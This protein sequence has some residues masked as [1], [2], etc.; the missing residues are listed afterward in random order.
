MD[1]KNIDYGSDA[2]TR[3]CE[4][5][6]RV[7]RV[8]LGLSLADEDLSE[9]SRQSHFG[10]FDPAGNLVACVI[11]VRLSPTR[12]KI[13]Q[14]AVCGSYQNQG[15]GRHIIR[16]L[17]ARL[18]EL[19]H[20]EVFMHARSGAVGFYE[21]LGYRKAGPEFVEV[22]IPHFLMEKRLSAREAGVV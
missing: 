9:E 21:K 2:F 15:W 1:F 3:E 13:R 11:A 8:P 19:G 7:L 6:E 12:A 20:E 18:A 22:G 4:L 10:L 17:E 16:C 5:R 14:M